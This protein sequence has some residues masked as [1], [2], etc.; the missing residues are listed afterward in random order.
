MK[1]YLVLIMIL[2]ECSSTYVGKMSDPYRKDIQIN[3]YEIHVIKKSQTSY[4]AFGGDSFGVDVLD[5]KKSQIRAIEQ[6]SGCHV[7]DSEYS[8]VF[9]RT[10]HAQVECDRN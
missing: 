4:E 2:T 6:V 1:K 7:I 8:S 5:L 3:K 10:L 9:I